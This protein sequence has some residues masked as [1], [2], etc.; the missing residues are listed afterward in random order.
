MALLSLTPLSGGL[1][2]GWNIGANGAA[3][4]FGTAVA[5]RAISF[6]RAILLCSLGIVAGAALQG[7][8]GIATLSGLTRQT[9]ASAFIATVAT[10]LTGLVMTRR[11]IPVSISQA[12]VG[13]ILGISIFQGAA[14]F[15]GLEKIVLCW[16]GTPLGAMLIAAIIYFPLGWLLETVPMSI[17]TRDKL[18]W[19]GLVLVGVYG[20]YALGANNVANATGVFSGKFAG[21]S[22][23]MLALLG[24]LSIAA[25]VMTYSRRV[26]YSVGAGIM[27]LD[28]FTALVAVLAMSLTVHVFAFLGVPVSSSQ[29]IV[30][31][32]LGI[33]LVRGIQAVRGRVLRNIILGWLATPVLAFALAV[34]G[35]AILIWGGR[36]L[37]RFSF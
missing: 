34:V 27:P 28:A 19:S 23:R 4:V 37:D 8:E 18:I 30:G 24:G 16:L 32:I 20:S 7:A 10:G 1:F 36:V 9:A 31:A 25:G 14:D 11:G 33:G 15:S 29:G 22:D 26:I 3:D 5:T 6:R 2:L 21:V 17:L 12:I 35:Y 13:A